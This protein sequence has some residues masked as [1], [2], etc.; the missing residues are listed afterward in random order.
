MPT[1]TPDNI[2]YADGTTPASLAT[3]TSA[4][5]TSVQEALNVREG[6]SYSWANTT[7]R[8]GQTG[9]STGDIGYQIDSQVYYIYNGVSWEIWAK[10]PASYSPTF[11]GFTVSASSFTYSIASGV[12]RIT[13]KATLSS[14]VTAIMTISTPSGYNIDL[15]SVGAAIP[16]SQIGFGGVDAATDHPLGVRVSTATAVALSATAYNGA[17]AGVAYTTIVNTGATV[18]KTWASGDIFYVSFLYPVA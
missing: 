18:P 1:T 3:I 2:Y 17:A 9:M 7:A 11:G 6:H 10:A 14:V 12:V 16:A 15:T 8:S 4:M 13:G 5:A